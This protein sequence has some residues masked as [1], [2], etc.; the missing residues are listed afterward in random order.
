MTLEVTRSP[1]ALG[2]AFGRSV[3][4]S[5]RW[6][7]LQR[8]ALQGLLALG[9]LDLALLQ[10]PEPWAGALSWQRAALACAY[11]SGFLLLMLRRWER[12]AAYAVVLATVVHLI[13]LPY[14]PCGQQAPWSLDLLL[15]VTLAASAFISLRLGDALTLLSLA[16]L[17]P[18][19]WFKPSWRQ[20]VPLDHVINLGLSL[21]LQQAAM[22]ALWRKVN[23]GR[24][25]LNALSH[26]LSAHL[27]GVSLMS[28]A[29]FSEARQ[30]VL[31]L[32]LRLLEQDLAG[33]GAEAGRLGHVLDSCRRALPPVVDPPP[34]GRVPQHLRDVRRTLAG[35]VLVGGFTAAALAWLHTRLA[36]FDMG[37]YAPA[38]AGLLGLI[39]SAYYSRWGRRRWQFW[40][41]TLVSLAFLLLMAWQI[42]ARAQGLPS[43]YCG[44]LLVLSLVAMADGLGL[45]L[46]CGGLTL[47]FVLLLARAQAA[48]P[49]PVALLQLLTMLG[50]AFAV[51]RLPRDLLTGLHEEGAALH[52]AAATRRRLVSTL[53]HD[54][55]NPL[56]EVLFQLE[57]RRDPASIARLA[58]R[59]QEILD[60]AARLDGG[61]GPL[62]A[63]E[64]SPLV[65]ALRDL[66][67]DR[68]RAKGLTLRVDLGKGFKVSASPV[69]LRESVLGNLLNNAIKFSPPGGSIVLRA[70]RATGHRVEL[71]LQDQ[72]GGVPPA[73]LAALERGQR[74]PSARG[75]GGEAGSGYGLSLARDYMAQMG[76]ELR[77]EPGEGGGTRAVLAL[78]AA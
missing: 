53:V 28:R 12:P 70:R 15:P 62:Q 38:W 7:A 44:A 18:L 31:D 29:A 48:A 71:L 2:K 74:P 59:M 13:S 5:I 25:E 69:L 61:I 10:A 39:A 37:W 73:V 33:A 46:A 40:A 35:V 20:A 43:N 23:A 24:D 65:K 76:G 64:L 16:A 21:A 72:G 57:A 77:L 75:T 66:Y 55:A 52:Q 68:L 36:G 3:N 47:A 56:Q 54:V 60:V 27:E 34:P 41:G 14:L 17:A 6:Q 4:H 22:R 32:R 1:P 50:A 8:K 26:G 30:C 58:A 63:V 42:S 51:W 11:G 19:P 78:G 49:F 67:Q 45:L 9:I